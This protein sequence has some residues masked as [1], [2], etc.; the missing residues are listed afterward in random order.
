V[1]EIHEGIGGPQSPD[2]FLSRDHLAGLFQQ[3]PKDCCRLALQPDFD[4]LFVELFCSRVKL[5]HPEVA[6]V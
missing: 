1:V 2:E 5:E 6:N 4:P 3:H